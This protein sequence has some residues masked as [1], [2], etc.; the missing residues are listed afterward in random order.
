[1]AGLEAIGKDPEQYDPSMA[2]LTEGQSGI[3]ASAVSQPDKLPLAAG[4]PVGEI[5]A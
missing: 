5:A 2:L 1:M 4:K 3:P